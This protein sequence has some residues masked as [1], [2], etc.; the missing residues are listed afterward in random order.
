[1][2]EAKLKQGQTLLSV[3]SSRFLEMNLTPRAWP[4]HMRHQEGV[5]VQKTTKCYTLALM[6][7]LDVPSPGL[8]VLQGF[9]TRKTGG[10]GHDSHVLERGSV[11]WLKSVQASG[12]VGDRARHR[13]G[14]GEWRLGH[15]GVRILPNTFKHK[16]KENRT[17]RTMS[18]RAMHFSATPR[19]WLISSEQILEC[20][21]GLV[22]FCREM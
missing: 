8:D 2:S 9:T 7:S 16:L 19:A 5:G 14:I 20:R 18:I 22:K 11:S 1:M 12:Y 15:S 10:F 21:A 4:T 17:L 13:P 3:L 6:L